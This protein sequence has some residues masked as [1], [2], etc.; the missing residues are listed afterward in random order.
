MAFSSEQVAES[1]AVDAATGAP[2]A[3]T[4]R[5]RTAHPRAKAAAAVAINARVPRSIGLVTRVDSRTWRKFRSALV[6]SIL[7]PRAHELEVAERDAA[8]AGGAGDVPV[9]RRQDAVDIAPFELAHDALAC[10]GEL[11]VLRDD[12]R[13]DVHSAV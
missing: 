11:E 5:G 6:L 7:Q 1:S 3:D 9:V 13:H 8:R 2:A 12:E 4:V 10:G